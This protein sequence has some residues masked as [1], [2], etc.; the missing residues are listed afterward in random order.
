MAP[1]F[2]QSEEA[3]L[4]KGVQE[5]SND[6][7][8]R[9]FW[10][11][12]V[13][14]GFHRHVCRVPK[15]KKLGVTTNFV[16]RN[17]R[18]QCWMYSRRIDLVC[19]PFCCLFARVYCRLKSRRD[20]SRAKRR[21]RAGFEE[22]GS[23]DRRSRKGARWMGNDA[24]NRAESVEQ[25]GRRRE[26]FATFSGGVWGQGRSWADRRVF[27]WQGHCSPCGE[28][29]QRSLR[30]SRDHENVDASPARKTRERETACE[31]QFV[32]LGVG[33]RKESRQQQRAAEC[34]SL[35]RWEFSNVEFLL[36]TACFHGGQCK[37]CR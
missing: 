21:K 12:A 34:P 35:S 30:C 18:G 11:E 19:H 15:M 7:R 9:Y 13:A 23:I 2:V 20:L 36:E 16:E 8:P 31:L 5:I 25:A 28:C 22:L 32:P 6:G 4:C 24:E 26:S 37:Q 3:G 14:D 10:Q 17:R 33:L 29:R 27:R 1:L